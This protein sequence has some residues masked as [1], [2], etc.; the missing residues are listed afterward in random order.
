MKLISMQKEADDYG[1]RP[2]CMP[3]KYGY[4]L[5]LYLDEDQCEALGISKALNAGT[6]VTLQANAIVTSAT[7]TLERDG[8][9]KGPDV[10]ISLQI[11]DL[12]L[13]AGGVLK[14]AATLLYGT[15]ADDN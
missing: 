2:Y 13:N 8:D 14:N 11:T 9:D 6:Q 5:T 1:D 15:R 12:G 7:E 4:G 10:S 3:A